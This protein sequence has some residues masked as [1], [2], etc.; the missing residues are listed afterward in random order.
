MDDY[1]WSTD[2]YHASNTVTMNDY[3]EYYMDEDFELIFSDG[4]YAEIDVYGVVYE[5]HA[6]GD[7]FNHR[8]QFKKKESEG[9]ND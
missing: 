4:S 8:I 5:V 7:S 6:S 3:L 1:F 9:K 2:Y